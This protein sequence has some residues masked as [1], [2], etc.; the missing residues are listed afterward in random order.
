MNAAFKKALLVLFTAALPM[1][2][3]CNADDCER[4]YTCGLFELTGYGI[5]E[6]AGVPADSDA[7]A[8]EPQEPS[9]TLPVHVPDALVAPPRCGRDRTSVVN[10]CGVFVSATLG[11]D[12]NAGNA[13][14]PVQTLQLALNLSQKR[15][16]VV[17]ACDEVFHESVWLPPGTTLVGGLDCTADWL[18]ESPLARTKIQASVGQIALIAAPADERSLVTRVEMRAIDATWPSGSSIAALALDGAA[19]DFVDCAFASGNAADGLNGAAFPMSK[20]TAADGPNGSSGEEACTSVTP[21]G[22][23]LNVAVCQG[24]ATTAGGAGGKG[25]L[26]SG[27]DGTS[28]LPGI[29]TPTSAGAFG[30]GETLLS[31]CT[32]GQTGADGQRGQDGAGGKGYGTLSALGYIGTNGRSGQ[33]GTPGQGGGGAGGARGGSLLCAGAVKGG[34]GGGSGGAGGC[35]GSGGPGG[36]FGG[37]SI[38]LAIGVAEVSAKTS[39]FITGN[40]GNGGSGAMFQLGGQGG[41]EGQGGS[42]HASA[43]AGC[44]GGKGGRGGDGGYGGGGLGGP[45]VAVAHKGAPPNIEFSATVLGAPGKGGHGNPNIPETAGEDGVSSQVLWLPDAPP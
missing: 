14:T 5:P 39:T 24:G 6:D 34:A 29:T 41:A 37:A 12:E 18:L 10:G 17:Y 7:R 19:I 20:Q 28:G 25:G 22:G 13:T 23:A 9:G 45:S 44:S 21:L 8:D 42:A 31:L 27:F 33:E 40:G 32:P 35:G 1:F 36:A 30:K 2:V 15:N 16:G 38:A 26:G 3:G 11:N 43:S 4:S